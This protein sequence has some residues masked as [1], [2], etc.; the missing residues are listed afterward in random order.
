[1]IEKRQER[2]RLDDQALGNSEMMYRDT[3]ESS[4]AA[5]STQRWRGAEEPAELLAPE[6]L[7]T[8]SS[9]SSGGTLIKLPCRD[10]VILS[11]RRYGES[12]IP[13]KNRAGRARKT[14]LTWS[15]RAVT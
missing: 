15:E 3:E 13:S 9:G 1:M 10:E 12:S 5:A 6:E 14:I 11:A 2:Q 7:A 8:S 4:E